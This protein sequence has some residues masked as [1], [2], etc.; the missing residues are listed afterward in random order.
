MANATGN[1]SSSVLGNLASVD[2]IIKIAPLTM[3]YL[4]I[5]ALV[6]AASVYVVE[7]FK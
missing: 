3:A 2:L 1:N 5:L 4:V 6:V 7:K